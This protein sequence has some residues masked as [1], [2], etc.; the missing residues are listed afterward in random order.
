MAVRRPSL[1]VQ[2][3]DPFKNELDAA[4]FNREGSFRNNNGS[5]SNNSACRRL[6]RG[7]ISTAMAATP[8]S[9]AP[10]TQTTTLGDVM[11]SALS[12]VDREKSIV[13]ASSAARRKWQGRDISS[14]IK[15]PSRR[16][17]QA[18]AERG[19]TLLAQH[20]VLGGRDESDDLEVLKKYGITHILNVANLPNCFEDKFVYKHVPLHDAVDTNIVDHMPQFNAFISHVE[21]IH[22]RVLIHCVSGVSRSVAVTI[23]HFVMV[24]RIILCDAYNYTY[25]C[26]P[27]ISPNDGFKLQMAQ[28]EL[29]IFGFSSVCGT[30]AGKEWDFYEWNRIRQPIHANQ[31]ASN[32][33]IARTK[34][35]FGTAP[36]NTLECCC[37]C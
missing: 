12:E 18:A 11:D 19:P 29:K 26:R 34:A 16:G 35:S 36:S 28:M 17:G 6:S 27:F 1:K 10:P 13:S 4:P 14:I 37:T 33:R 21:K 15:N 9:T 2:P 31:E 3:G 24:H 8:R 30:Q 23:L 22:G 32:V 20:I 5:S 7:N 25:S